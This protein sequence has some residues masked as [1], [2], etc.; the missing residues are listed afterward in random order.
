[1]Q[2]EHHN[3]DDAHETAIETPPPIPRLSP[4][5][6]PNQQ[7]SRSHKEADAVRGGEGED[8]E[9]LPQLR[10]TQQSLQLARAPAV[11][12]R[13]PQEEATEVEEGRGEVAPNASPNAQPLEVASL[14]DSSRMER[15]LLPPPPCKQMRPSSSPE[16]PSYHESHEPPAR[17]SPRPRNP[18]LPISP[19]E[20]TK[21]STTATTSVPFAQRKSRD[22]RG[23]SGLVGLV[24]PSFILAASR[25]GLQTR[26]QLLL[27]SR[28]RTA[29]FHPRDSGAA[30]DA[31]FPR[32][33]YP[34]TS[35]VGVR[36]S[37]IQS[38]FPDSHPSPAVRRALAHEFCQRNVLIHVP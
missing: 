16:S 32:T 5:A 22:T 30:Q 2:T 27:A 29:S 24:G 7:Q 14:E 18:R 31:T 38:R 13:H 35:T 28:P 21:T 4:R 9:A 6:K 10:H 34:R 3:G 20:R 8:V 12:H 37:W 23:A 33:F 11:H 26:A 17:S 36:R 1:V 25:N 15:M 19:Q